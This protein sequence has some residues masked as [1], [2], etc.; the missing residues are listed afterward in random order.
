MGRCIVSDKEG[1]LHW[2]YET[3]WKKNATSYI[4]FWRTFVL[5]ALIPAAIMVLELFVREGAHA[6]G[7]ELLRLY[8]IFFCIITVLVLLFYIAKLIIGGTGSIIVYDMNQNGITGRKLPKGFTADNAREYIKA[9]SGVKGK[10]GLSF[11]KSNANANFL[12]VYNLVANKKKNTIKLVTADLSHNI[13]YVGK[14]DFDFVLEYILK[15]CPV[16]TVV[17]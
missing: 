5:L 11:S 4:T 17:K 2:F 9:A 1:V 16:K 6:A 13:I 14:D 10:E 12:S 3:D 8:A 7:K 15:Y